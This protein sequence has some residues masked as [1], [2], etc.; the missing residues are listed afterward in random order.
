MHRGKT[1][2][3]HMLGAR[4]DICCHKVQCSLHPQRSD[5]RRTNEPTPINFQLNWLVFFVFICHRFLSLN[6]HEA[7]VERGA[8]MSLFLGA[9]A[10]LKDIRSLIV[11]PRTR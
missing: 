7:L 3:N 10:R 5:E 1:M 9:E 11:L 8:R 6:I 4:A 2:R